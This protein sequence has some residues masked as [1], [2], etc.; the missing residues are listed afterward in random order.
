MFPILILS[1]LLLAL[2]VLLYYS[3][4]PRFNKID[5]FLRFPILLW[6]PCLLLEQERAPFIEKS[7]PLFIP[8]KR[9][10]PL[11]I[12]LCSPFF[13]ELLGPHFKAFI[14]GLFMPS[15]I[16]VWKDALC[17]FQNVE[18]LTVSLVLA[19]FHKNLHGFLAIVVETLYSWRQNS[20][21]RAV[22]PL[23]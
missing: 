2:Q 4:A 3:M 16:S 1:S 21:K 7:E 11:A 12:L 9:W 10:F 23:D 20:Y 13:L 15:V 8:S 17:V 6:D 18:H 14:V 22:V 19:T 5:G